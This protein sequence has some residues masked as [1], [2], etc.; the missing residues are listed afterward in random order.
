MK[1]AKHQ[2]S[3]ITRAAAACVMII[4]LITCLCLPSYA[5]GPEDD[6]VPDDT[7]GTELQIMQ[8]SQL[9]IRLGSDWAGAEFEM[10]TDVGEYPGTIPVSADGTLHVE[11]GGSET[12]LLKLVETPAE[13]PVQATPE[14]IPEPTPDVL[15]AP[16][17]E[18][19]EPEKE[20]PEEEVPPDPEESDNSPM[21]PIIIFGTGV[22]LAVGALVA[23]KVISKRREGSEF[24]SDDENDG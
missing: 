12:Y 19:V 13:P 8:P 10:E 17:E 1:Q 4:Y 20:V 18:A 22:V 11:I 6:Y 9:E 14:P 21:V 2:G 3:M 5:N 23:M 24:G 7:D 15:E 16:E